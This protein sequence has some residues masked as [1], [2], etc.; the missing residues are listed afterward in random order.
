M[1]GNVRSFSFWKYWFSELYTSPNVNIHVYLFLHL[2]TYW[3]HVYMM[4]VSECACHS[5]PVE[6]RG[7]LARAGSF[8]LGGWVSGINLGSLCLAASTLTFRSHLASF[9]R[10]HYTT[11]NVPPVAVSTDLLTRV[12]MYWNGAQWPM[13]NTSFQKVSHLK[14]GFYQR[15]QRW[16]SHVP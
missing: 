7:Q 4:Y 14:L 8:L 5:T 1:C 3:L 12:T 6:V 11:S 13:T 10:L 15:Q 9:N 16:S 2:F